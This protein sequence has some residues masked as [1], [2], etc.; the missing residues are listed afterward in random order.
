[1]NV[2]SERRRRKGSGETDIRYRFSSRVKT[3][4][5]ETRLPGWDERGSMR[6]KNGD[7]R[8]G[9]SGSGVAVGESTRRACAGRH[10]GKTETIMPSK[11]ISGSSG[12]VLTTLPS[13]YVPHPATGLLHLPRF[14][15]KCRH[16]KQHGA[17]P[18]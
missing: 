12:D 16:V 13:A 8:G 18:P 5:G 3:P 6:S 9:G 10:P 4:S 11:P 7:K 15:A 14:L 1:H 17:L 2:A